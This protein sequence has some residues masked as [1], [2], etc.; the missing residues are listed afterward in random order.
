MNNI[1][2]GHSSTISSAFVVAGLITCVFLITQFATITIASN[3]ALNFGILWLSSLIAGH[4]FQMLDIALLGSLLSGIILKNAFNFTVHPQ[5]S[6]AVR[7]VGLCIILLISS[8][9]INVDKIWKLGVV[10]CM[11]L[12]CL[13]GMMEAITSASLAVL[14]FD[15]PLSLS[16]ALGYILSAVS[17][18]IVLPGMMRLKEQGYGVE[19][20]IPSLIM[21][22]ASF[23]DIMA[24]TGFTVSIGIALDTETEN[25]FLSTF[26]HGPLQIFIG[27]ATGCL[28]A[29]IVVLTR[30]SPHQWQRT[31]I[32][33]ELSMIVTYLSKIVHLDGV[34]AVST[35]FMGLVSQLIWRQKQLLEH[36]GANYTFTESSC[37]SYLHSIGDDLN[38]VWE[39]VFRPLLFGSI[40]SVLDFDTMQADTILKACAIVFLGVFVRLLTAYA[41][42][43]GRGLTNKE[44]QFIS[45]SWVPKATVQAALCGLP[46]SYVKGR[47]S[48]ND[49]YMQLL[50]WTEQMAVTAILAILIT[51]PIGLLS[52]QFLGTRL[53]SR[54]EQNES[55]LKVTSN[56][57]AQASHDSA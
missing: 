5:L 45:V 34:G 8:V 3:D 48:E 17:P 55:A 23:D 12:T 13:P 20:G 44:R 33:F 22:A 32:A 11:R 40:G 18:A 35:L 10:F 19:Q 38:T 27:V 2:R 42:V 15:M 24:I 25:I 7:T 31:M 36:I 28:M 9:E 52:I 49:E 16:L 21:A 29:V 46:I 51:A 14:L 47:M 57:Q 53:L 1:R 26:I 41:V 4:L 6:D 50:M 43:G 30:F 39:I 37:T 54:K 56:E